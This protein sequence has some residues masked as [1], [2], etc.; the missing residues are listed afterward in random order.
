MKPQQTE[1]V[2][3]AVAA[4]YNID[5]IALECRR[6]IEAI[7]DARAL[8]YLILRISSERAGWFGCGKAF[9]RKP[10][11]AC[12]G[13]RCALD[14]IRLYPLHRAAYDQ[15]AEL[16]LN[17]LDHPQAIPMSTHKCE[18]EGC[19][20]VTRPGEL[21]CPSH[22]QMVPPALQRTIWKTWRAGRY[23]RH[24]E[25]KAAAIEAVKQM[26]LPLESRP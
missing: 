13:A 9:D 11:S 15:A 14:R 24:R 5:V 8:G 20:A 2:K 1:A 4:A 21:M 17:H 12:V 7:T 18:A 25:A 19:A 22:W 3:R 23:D 26:G 16:F 6:G 10:S